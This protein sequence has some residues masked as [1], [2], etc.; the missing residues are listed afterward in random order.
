MEYM[1]DIS[2]IVTALCA[3]VALVFTARGWRRARKD[4]TEQVRLSSVM[5]TNYIIYEKV[6]G[7]V[8]DILSKSLSFM[9]S[10]REHMRITTNI[11]EKWHG[12]SGYSAATEEDKM[13]LLKDWAE[14]TQRIIDETYKLQHSTLELTRILDMS[15]ADFGNNSKVYNALWLTYHNLN[16]S[17]K[18]VIDRWSNLNLEYTTAQQYKW[19]LHDT[20]EMMKEVDEFRSCIDDVLKYVYNKLVAE[21]MGKPKKVIDLDE[22]RRIITEDGL[23]DNR[24]KNA[25]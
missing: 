3:I 1:V 4:A 13:E 9:N 7:S 18:K 22:R 11:L 20:D 14:L 21:P 5:S 17:I 2:Q 10:I 8:N 15:G 16:D 6:F 19:L 23:K 12:Q 25:S 24:I